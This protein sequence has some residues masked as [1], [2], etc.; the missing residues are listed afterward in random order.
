MVWLRLRISSIDSKRTIQFRTN[1]IT[2]TQKI[3]TSGHMN[4]YIW[5]INKKHIFVC[6]QFFPLKTFEENLNYKILRYL[7]VRR[8]FE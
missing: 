1:S 6:I 8:C 2:S 5:K 4:G 7:K 3:T